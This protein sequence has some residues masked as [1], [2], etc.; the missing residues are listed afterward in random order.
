MNHDR[1]NNFKSGFEKYIIFFCL[2]ASYVAI[3][4]PVDFNLFCF[5]SGEIGYDLEHFITCSFGIKCKNICSD[6]SLSFIL[7]GKQDELFWI[8]LGKSFFGC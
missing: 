6:E 2:G 8:V 5:H 7:D 1:V 4:I 3:G